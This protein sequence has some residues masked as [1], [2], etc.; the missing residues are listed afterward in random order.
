L[1]LPPFIFQVTF[2]FFVL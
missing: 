1:H 2:A